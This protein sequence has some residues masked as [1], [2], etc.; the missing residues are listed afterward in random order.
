[1]CF[2]KSFAH[3]CACWYACRHVYTCTCRSREVCTWL[4]MCARVCHNKKGARRMASMTS[5]SGNTSSKQQQAQRKQ[6][7]LNTTRER[8]PFHQSITAILTEQ[9]RGTVTN[10]T[11]VAVY[12]TAKNFRQRK[13]LSKSTV[14]QFVR[15]LF[16]SNV[17]SLVLSSVVRFACLSFVFTFMTISDPTLVV[18]WKI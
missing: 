4:G 14:R 6:N 11:L 18:L 2:A 12:C 15:N 17:G 16:S 13:I 7:N 1:M 9:T 3:G 8:G 5:N 10:P